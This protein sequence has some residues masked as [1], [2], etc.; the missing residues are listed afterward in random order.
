MAGFLCPHCGERVDIFPVS[1]EASLLRD[2]PL[3]GVVPLDLAT[4]RSGDSGQPIVVT[5]PES[6]VSD[7]F[8]TIAGRVIERIASLRVPEQ[9]NAEGETKTEAPEDEQ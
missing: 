1:S 4:A 9:A 5:M 7:E 2:M 6:I 3:L 8:Y